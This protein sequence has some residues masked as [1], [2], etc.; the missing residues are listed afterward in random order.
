MGLFG[1]LETSCESFLPAGDWTR[2]DGPDSSVHE[3]FA[4]HHH[5]GGD[6]LSVSYTGADGA[7]AQCWARSGGFFPKAGWLLISDMTGEVSRLAVD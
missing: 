6:Q 1:T 3:K 7:A 5:H 2:L 4:G